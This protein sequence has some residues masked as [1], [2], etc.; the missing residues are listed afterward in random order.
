MCATK[1]VGNP[2]RK[3]DIA[4]HLF[5]KLQGATASALSE[6]VEAAKKIAMKHGGDKIWPA[7]M[8]EEAEVI[9]TDW[10]NG[11]YT[12]LAYAGEGA[13]AWTMDILWCVSQFIIPSRIATREGKVPLLCV[14]RCPQESQD[15]HYRHYT[16]IAE[17]HQ[18]LYSCQKPS[19]LSGI[20]QSQEDMSC[21]TVQASSAPAE[22]RDWHHS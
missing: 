1:T 15:L 5:F 21:A 4:D 7:K 20:S 11:L 9:W 10:K 22:H 13:K 12:G 16:V 6:S 14:C 19:S 8:Q 18:L 17:E 2:A 3:Y